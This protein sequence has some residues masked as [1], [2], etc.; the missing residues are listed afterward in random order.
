MIREI[1]PLHH[2]YLRLAPSGNSKASD[3]RN[4]VSY[5]CKLTSHLFQREDVAARMRC[6]ATDCKAHRLQWKQSQNGDHFKAYLACL[7]QC[8]AGILGPPVEAALPPPSSRASSRMSSR[9]AS[10]VSSVASSRHGETASHDKVFFDVGQMNTETAELFFAFS[11]A[12]NGGS[13]ESRPQGFLC[14]PLRSSFAVLLP[15]SAFMCSLNLSSSVA[16]FSYREDVAARMKCSATECRAYRLQWHKTQ[17]REDGKKY[18]GCLDQCIAEGTCDMVQFHLVI[19]KEERFAVQIL[20]HIDIERHSLFLAILHPGQPAG[21]PLPSS[22]A[23][24]RVSSRSTTRSSAL[25]VHHK[26]SGAHMRFAHNHS[27]KQTAI[28]IIV[29]QSVLV[30]LYVNGGI[31]ICI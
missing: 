25:N 16:C 30:E 18:F 12:S 8:I 7:D 4:Y 5:T 27:C 17:D 11:M 3:G 6:S 10:R 14:V 21:L 9:A 13:V 31:L 28:P 26:N 23:S 29:R 22:R 20:Y 24:S 1:T 2:Y 19:W 15:L